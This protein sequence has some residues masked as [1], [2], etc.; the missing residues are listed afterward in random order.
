MLSARLK[1]VMLS[2]QSSTTSAEATMAKRWCLE[3]RWIRSGR[4]SDRDVF[5][6]CCWDINWLINESRCQLASSCL[7]QWVNARQRWLAVQKLLH[8]DN[9]S[10]CIDDDVLFCNMFANF[11]V[12]K[13]DSI[14]STIPSQLIHIAPP[15]IDPVC[16]YPS[17]QLLEPVTSLEFSKLLSTIPPKSCCLDCIPTAIIKQC[18]SVFFWAYCFLA[19]LSF[20]QGTFPSKFNHASRPGHDV[21]YIHTE[22]R[23]GHDV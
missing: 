23:P 21:N 11:F 19:N 5:R 13:I 16:S 2:S 4:I 6:R 15:P 9:K 22:W 3:R 14:K 20:S 7:G 8:N 18:S 17:L 1:H 12:S 10:A